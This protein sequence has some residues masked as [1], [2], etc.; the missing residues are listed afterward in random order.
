[1]RQR[2]KCASCG[3]RISHL[4]EGGRGQNPFREIGHAHHMRHVKQG[5]TSVLANCVVLCQACHYSAHEGGN[6]R[7]GTEVGRIE[8]FPHFGG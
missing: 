8:D 3:A 6:Y 5:G 7:S 2:F 1:V 4:G